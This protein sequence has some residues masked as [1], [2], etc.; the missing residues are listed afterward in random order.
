MKFMR[1]AGGTFTD[2]FT[3][4]KD[5]NPPPNQDP[6]AAFT[7]SAAGR[8]ASFDATTSSDPDGTVSSW[9]WDFGDGQTGTGVKPTHDYA[10]DGKYTVKLTVTDDKGDTNSVSHD[11]TVAAAPS[12][13]ASDAFERTVTNGWGT[14]DVGGAWTLKG[15]ASR[16]KVAGGT[17]QIQVPAGS[18]LNAD[19]NAVSSDSTR[20]DVDF[21]VDKIAGDTYLTSVGRQVGTEFYDAK[22]RIQPGGVAKLY[23]FR[24][25]NDPARGP[26]VHAQHRLRAERAVPAEPGG[27][28]HLSDDVGHQGLEDLGP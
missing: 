3:I 1:G 26:R 5:A 14:A 25:S 10:A 11:V 19:L 7:S 28:G 6:V 13:I 9:D 2:G 18:T 20:F 16:F 8:T 21:V 27:E 12:A 22:L 15:T 17:G 23:L 4:S 24:G